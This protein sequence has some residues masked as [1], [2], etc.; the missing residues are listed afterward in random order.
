M[1]RFFE[2]LIQGNESLNYITDSFPENNEICKQMLI[3]LNNNKTNIKLDIDIKNSYYTFLNNTIYLC[4][5]EINKRNYQRICT[6]AHECIHS[7]QSK[8]LQILN[9]VLSNIELILFVISFICVLLKF[10]VILVLY[11]YILV[12]V[13]AIIP[14]LILE[15]DATIKSIYLSKKYMKNKISDDK[16]DILIKAYKH[17]IIKFF[18]LFITSLFIG[19]LLRIFIIFLTIQILK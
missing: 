14:R 11:S 3:I 15:I 1:F 13:I 18:P 17:Q 19:K 7:I 2:K 4:D 8:I 12:N 5:K 6:V 9:F 16:L 10:N